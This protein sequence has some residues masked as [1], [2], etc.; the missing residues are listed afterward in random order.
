[1]EEE[2]G[3]S[4]EVLEF[5]HWFMLKLQYLK[6]PLKDQD[7]EDHNSRINRV[8]DFSFERKIENS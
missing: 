1:M 2:E 6:A 4:A 3:F 5:F 7:Y 8:I